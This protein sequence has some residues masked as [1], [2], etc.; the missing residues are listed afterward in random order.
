MKGKFI[1]FE[2]CEGVGKSTH[3]RLLK[4]YIEKSGVDAIFTREPGG[5]PVCEA[6]RKV[7]LDKTYTEMSPVCEAL[8]YAASRAQL[9]DEV[10]IPA[11]ESGKHVF[12]DRYVDS[13]F[14]YQ[15]YAR[16]LGFENIQSINAPAIHGAIPDVTI[17]LDLPP[18]Q[19]FSRKGGRDKSDRIELETMQF[20]MDVYKGY[21]AVAEKFPE[22]IICIK[23]L[24][25]KFETHKLIVDALKDRG[26]L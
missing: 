4:E 19:A 18:D 21:K 24:G 23:P 15:G 1:T 2:G 26:I 14:A 17:F 10:I 9:V 22:R 6:V 13:S 12:C 3:I 20:H 8:L 5:V 11:L 25:T 16:N 7:I